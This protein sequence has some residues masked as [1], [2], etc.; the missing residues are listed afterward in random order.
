M[1]V[2]K[3]HTCALMAFAAAIVLVLVNSDFLLTQSK[4]ALNPILTKSIDN[5]TSDDPIG[6][7]GTQSLLLPLGAREGVL[8]HWIQRYMIFHESE[9][10]RFMKGNATDVKFLVL[11]CTKG[12]R[13]GTVDRL[14]PVP[15]FVL[16]AALSKRVLLIKWSVPSELENFLVPPRGGMDWSFPPQLSLSRGPTTKGWFEKPTPQTLKENMNQY[17]E[18]VL[19]LSFGNGNQQFAIMERMIAEYTNQE[20]GD[21]DEQGAQD[22]SAIF[23]TLFSKLFTPSTRL[24]DFIINEMSE[25]GLARGNFLGVHGR[26][27]YPAGRKDGEVFYKTVEE[28]KQILR[29]AIDCALNIKEVDD[30]RV[31]V[32]CDRIETATIV[33]DEYESEFPGVVKVDVGVEEDQHIAF[34]DFNDGVREDVTVEPFLPT[35]SDL[36]IMGMARCVVH[37]VGGF[38]SFSAM[39]AGNA[40]SYFHRKGEKRFRMGEHTKC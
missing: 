25:L 23:P 8:P 24:A 16:L 15:F 36:W 7:I 10:K 22:W 2:S 31:Y 40:C 28:Q 30:A 12:C 6:D 29:H 37:G 21:D 13:G 18:Q 32:A 39:L 3:A 1:L 9:K 19:T 38:G 34:S 27:H 33:K 5:D 17:D 20:S 35:F 26:V 4:N 14:T 11:S